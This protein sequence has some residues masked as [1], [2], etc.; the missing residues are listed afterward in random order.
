MK[1]ID[2]LNKI[3]NGEEIKAKLKFKLGDI[4]ITYYG[5]NNYYKTPEYNIEY[6]D[7]GCTTHDFNLGMIIKHLNDEIEII[8]EEKKSLNDI[9][10]SYGL[11]R[12]EEK[13][14]PEKIDNNYF[15]EL[16]DTAEILKLYEK[17]CEIIDY[18]KSKGE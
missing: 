3:A 1:V 14:I 9:R 15:L 6:I 16:N 5:T 4:I 18:L 7:K 2:L 13:K 8:E 17:Q 10:E 12:I 11:P